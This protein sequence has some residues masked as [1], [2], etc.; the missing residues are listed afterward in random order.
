MWNAEEHHMPAMVFAEKHNGGYQLPVIAEAKSLGY[1]YKRKTF[2]QFFN[3][4]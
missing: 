2:Q 3:G 1:R 4:F